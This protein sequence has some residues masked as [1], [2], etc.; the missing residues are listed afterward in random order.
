MTLNS[1]ATQLRCP[2]LERVGWWHLPYHARRTVPTGPSCHILGQ[3]HSDGSADRYRSRYPT[4]S[5]YIHTLTRI[6]CPHPHPHPTPHTPHPTPYILHPAP[7]TLYPTHPHPHPRP[8]ALSPSR[9]L[10]LSPSR[11]HTLT[12]SHPL[13]LSPAPAPTTLTLAGVLVEAIDL[14]RD[15]ATGAL[16]NS[17]PVHV[18]HSQVMKRVQAGARTRARA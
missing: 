4:P 1:D 10:A 6:L 14:A 8:L 2:R 9:P 3:C 13:T 7:Y 17:P 16:H 18:H 15:P 12:P 11:P 5:S